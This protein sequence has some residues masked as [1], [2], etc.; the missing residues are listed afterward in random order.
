MG[1][2]LDFANQTANSIR[3]NVIPA[4]LA[5]GISISVIVNETRFVYEILLD[6]KT[7]IFL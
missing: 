7:Q 4:L 1:F 2:K 3:K 6:D 5:V